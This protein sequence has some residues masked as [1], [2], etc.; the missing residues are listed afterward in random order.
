MD[1]IYVQQTHNIRNAK[2]IKKS[3]L[4]ILKSKRTRLKNISHLIYINLH[5]FK[6]WNMSKIFSKKKKNH[7]PIKPI[8]SKTSST[9]HARQFHN[10][11]TLHVPR[12]RHRETHSRH[13]VHPTD[14]RQHNCTHTHTHDQGV[15]SGRAGSGSNLTMAW[16]RPP[17]QETGR[18]R[19]P[20]VIDAVCGPVAHVSGQ[21]RPVSC[22]VNFVGKEVGGGVLKLLWSKWR[23]SAGCS[24]EFERSFWEIFAVTKNRWIV[25]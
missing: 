9:N 19:H 7:T 14:K 21:A 15:V 6:I 11:L 18:T 22:V 12:P 4:F 1:V 5:T 3:Q 23:F 20:I 2:P 25:D 8:S 24:W 16:V 17:N 10:Q 13:N